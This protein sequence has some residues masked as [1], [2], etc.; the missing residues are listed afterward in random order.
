[1]AGAAST[2]AECGAGAITR[3]QDIDP[4]ERVFVSSSGGGAGGG[5]DQHFRLGA[6]T[7]KRRLGFSSRMEPEELSIQSAGQPAC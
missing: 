7:A 1:M 2:W 4:A 3:C 5:C 6:P